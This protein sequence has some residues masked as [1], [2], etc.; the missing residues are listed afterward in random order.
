MRILHVAEAFGG[1]L[2]DV[3]CTIAEGAGRAGDDV[4]IAFGRRPET[5]A[6]LRDV[7]APPVELFPLEWGRRRPL[8]ELAAARELRRL[9]RAWEPDVV[10]LHS[11]VAGVVGAVV[12]PPDAAVVYSPHS[13]ESALPGDRTRRGL[14]RALE[15]FAVRRATVVGAVSPSEAELSQRLGARSV[16]VVENGIAELDPG[17]ALVRDLP[18]RPS[19]IAGGR[20]VPQRRP[21]A[22]AR[23]L[24]GLRDVADVAWVGG[25]GGGRGVAGQ[26]ALD[27]ASI[28]TTGW[29]ER[30][31]FLRRLEAATVYLHWT[32]WDGQPL[33]VLEALACDAVVIASDIAPNRH[34][35]GDAQVFNSEA[36][37][38]SAVRRAVADHD[39]A[40]ALRQSQRARRWRW[41]AV[42][43]VADWT[44]LYQRTVSGS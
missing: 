37:A 23:I 10:H 19:V 38:L 28:P 32:A 1:G 36:E 21:E 40:E 26:S 8:E 22:C 6:L 18:A 4:A 15:R 3:V 35:L 7:V 39:F 29:V 16:R 9:I 25:G 42:R 2:L 5:P 24:A 12:T 30:S 31:E 20:T 41:S 44:E 27:A 11:S 33:S 13:F 14:V 43:M 34:V 17:R